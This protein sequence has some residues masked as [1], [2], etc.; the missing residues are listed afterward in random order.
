MTEPLHRQ[1][2]ALRR[3]HRLAQHQLADLMG[4]WRSTI[5]RWERGIQSHS[6]PEADRHARTLH[7]R[8]V[9]LNQHGQIIGDL[10][11]LLPTLPDLRKQRG[12]SQS[13][14][15]RRMWSSRG[16]VA[17]IDVRIRAGHAVRLS[18]IAAYVAGMGCEVGLVPA[19]ALERAA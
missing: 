17:N 10:L 2:R 3:D 19:R 9:I 7:H 12:L 18:T 8:L 15:A 13:D 14:V 16:G 1:L 5:S 6:I 11:A 4:V